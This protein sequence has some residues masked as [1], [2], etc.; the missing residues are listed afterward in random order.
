MLAVES[1]LLLDLGVDMQRTAALFL[2]AFLCAGCGEARESREAAFT[3]KNGLRV[4]LRPV[5]GASQV[6]AVV[7]F[8]I[9]DDHDPK[10]KS[11]LAHLIEHLYITAAAGTSP[12]RDVRAFMAKYGTG[13][14][15]Q[16]GS[17]Y[18][19]LA[20]VFPAGD[21]DAELADAAAR[22]GSLSVAQADLDREKPRVLDELANMFGRIP[23]LA[24][25]NLAR[26]KVRPS[27]A[28]GRKGG[29]P[30]EVKRITLDD[31]HGALKRFCTP[32][33]AILVLA[34]GLEVA[35]ARKK[36]EEHFAAI[37]SG[38]KAPPAQT[39]PAA[40]PGAT[41]TV[42]AR[43]LQPG[44]PAFAAVSLRAPLP[45]DAGYPAFLVLAQRLTA[46]SGK[47]SAHQGHFPVNYAL[48]DDPEALTLSV[49]LQSG[50]SPEKAVER[51]N[52]F[53]DEGVGRPFARGE[54]QGVK[55][56]Y[57]FFLGLLDL[58]DAMAAKQP[59]GLAF[60]IG[61]RLQL[62][63]D[64][65]QLSKALDKLTPE[66]VQETAKKYFGAERRAA[67]AVIPE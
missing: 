14:N 11:G 53:I 36:V 39:V 31:V 38:E 9:G 43:P 51:M 37:P 52:A 62:G 21:L 15:A 46:S 6:A 48:L 27:P 47:L 24:A 65:A 66:G 3:L 44:M 34:G 23:P 20:T 28:G 63:L 41:E 8:D 13:W 26:E 33:N 56:T 67:V 4:V 61:R 54:I 60:S 57:G 35:A 55:N 42:H 12:A 59:Y 30:D 40:L 45:N 17:H 58:P 64:G 10:G 50:E 7:L 19:V 18:T 16:T 22:M 25:A 2:S 32:A 49:P 1:P 5:S 29:I